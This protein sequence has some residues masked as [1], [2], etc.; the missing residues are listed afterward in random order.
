MKRR[1]CFTART[2]DSSSRASTTTRRRQYLRL[3]HRLEG[4]VQAEQRYNRF[5]TL[6]YGL[7]YQ[8]VTDRS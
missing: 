6:L 7:S 5:T 2:G 8:R 1:A 4:T 3:G